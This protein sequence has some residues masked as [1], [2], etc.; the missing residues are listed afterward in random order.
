MLESTFCPHFLPY[1]TPLQSNTTS[2]DLPDD[3]FRPEET[4]PT[5][6]KKKVAKK[7]SAAVTHKRSIDAV[8]VS[9]LELKYWSWMT[10]STARAIAA[11]STYDGMGTV[12]IMN[13]RGPFNQKQNA[14]YP[15]MDF[16]KQRR[17]LE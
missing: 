1:L 6:P 16:L 11:S 14:K 13:H 12:L 8:D 17:R 2:F 3:V 7:A 5:R 9:R 10:K 15:R 4:R